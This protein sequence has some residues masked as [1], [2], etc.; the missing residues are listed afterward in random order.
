MKLLNLNNNYKATLS[1]ILSAI[2]FAFCVPV[3]KLLS[4]KISSTIM[5]GLLYLG[6]GL[7]LYF[8]TIIKRQN[9]ELTLTKKE[10]PY[11]IAM[12]LLD[13]S[14]I[15]LLMLG[16]SKTTGAN[17]SLLGNFELVATSFVA[18]IFFKELLSKRIWI[19]VIL[20]TIACI[21]LSFDGMNSFIFNIGSIFVLLSALCWGIENN[22]TKMLSIK[23]IRQ[24]TMIK[25]IFSGL[26]SLAIALVI[27]SNFPEIK[28]IVALLLLGFISYGVS[29]CLYIY[30]QRFLGAAKT[31][32][33]YATS[34]FW[35]V[36][37][38]LM[39]LGET[40]SIQF[41]IALII[42]IIGTTL[43]F[44]STKNS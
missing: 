7:G 37:F 11:I 29:V 21:I 16:I 43:I 4:P 24:I 17:A 6:A 32:S 35:S 14:A 42:M 41:Y 9:I 33:Y 15:I 44:Y 13:I 28:Y 5:G 18:C 8:T 26:G 1:V 27:G 39:F 40:P 36:V 30:A 22:C 2:L 25:G 10:L 19:S 31:A 34:P 12:V 20:I 3:S 23:D 38:C